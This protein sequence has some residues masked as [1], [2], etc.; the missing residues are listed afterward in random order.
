[1]AFAP[2]P[3]RIGYLTV[4]IKAFSDYER[5]VAKAEGHFN[6][7]EGIHYTAN[8][9]PPERV[10]TLIHEVLHAIWHTQAVGCSDAEEE[11]IVNSM[12]NGLTQVFRDNPR[13]IKFMLSDL[14]KAKK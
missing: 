3:A 2:S 13:L 14:A 11:R 7:D 10:N 5:V 9:E 12:A 4:P 1:M 6:P 8:R